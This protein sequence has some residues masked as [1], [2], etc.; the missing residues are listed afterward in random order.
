VFI[1]KFY[2]LK[3]INSYRQSL[4]SIVP[5]RS[6]V[7]VSS[8]VAVVFALAFV[9]VVSAPVVSASLVPVVALAPVEIL[10]LSLN[11]LSRCLSSLIQPEFTDSLAL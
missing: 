9:P 10:L 7:V 4:Q 6:L 5:V 3:I 2:L 1:L 11:L 8:L